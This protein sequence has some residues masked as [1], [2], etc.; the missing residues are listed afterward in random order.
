[1]VVGVE[2]EGGEALTAEI[3]KYEQLMPEP[4]TLFGVNNIRADGYELGRD[5]DITLLW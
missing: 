1:M 4:D 3:P 2:G 5:R